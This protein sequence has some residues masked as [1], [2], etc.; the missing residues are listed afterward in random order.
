MDDSSR[1]SKVVAVFGAGKCVKA[2]AE[3][4]LSE[5]VGEKLGEAGFC[6]ANGGYGGTMLGCSA[7]ASKYSARIIGITCRAF[8]SSEPNEYVTENIKVD[9]LRE[10]LFKLIDISDGFIVLGGGTGTLQELAM[11]WESKN[12][13]FECRE[14]PIIL[15]GDFWVPLV[16][17]IASKQPKAAEN[18]L[19]TKSADKAVEILK[20]FFGQ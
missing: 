13:G 17:L 9:S 14:K 10:R 11:I 2:D 1:D 18:I 8:G 4:E 19:I 15:L 5:Q 20:V 12:K 7:G 6:I 16:N 3:Y